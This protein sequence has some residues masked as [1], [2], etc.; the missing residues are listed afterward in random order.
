LEDFPW[1][2]IALWEKGIR[3]IAGSQANPRIVEY[4]KS[5]NLP[6]PDASS[7]ETAWCSAFVNWCMEKAGYA[8]TD[9]AWAKS[10]LTWGK[11]LPTPQKGCVVV[12]ERRM[13]NG[14]IGGHVGFYLGENTDTVEVFGGNQS[15]SVISFHYPKDG[16]LGSTKYRLLGYRV[17]SS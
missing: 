15:N 2:T 11:S 14:T 10:W 6:E 4:L 7:D 8:G 17:A 12:F 16:F 5:T 3:E 1:F 13:S 9:S